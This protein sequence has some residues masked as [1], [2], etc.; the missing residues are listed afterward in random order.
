MVSIIIPSYKGAEILQKNVP[1][2]LD[3]L[4]INNV[5]YEVIIVD[6][7]SDDN[8]RTKNVAEKLNCI[9]VENSKN[10]GK[11]AAIRNGILKA[12]GEVRIYTDADIPFEPDAISTIIKYIQVKEF[13]L[14]IGDR[15]LSQSE[16]FQSITLSR[17]FS[18][19]LFTFFVGRFV[20]TG[21]YDTQCGI[22]GFKGSVAVELFSK[23]TLNGFA[24][25]VELL[26]MSLKK[27]FDIKRIEVKLRNNEEESSVNLF[28]HSIPMIVDLFRIKINHIKG[29]YN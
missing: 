18:S 7:G 25:D 14:V 5:E 11:G 15:T 13:D 10:L 8:G 19:K 6:D 16:Y 27:N 3:Y 17:K 2:L 26:Y 22:K 12:K 9:Y 28:K 23:S 29:R 4:S 21:L 1:V 20:T 24:F